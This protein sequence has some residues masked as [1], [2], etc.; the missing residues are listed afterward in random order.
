MGS[1]IKYKDLQLI[2]KFQILFWS[3]FGQEYCKWLPF[4]RET[5]AI[6]SESLV[7]AKVRFVRH[8]TAV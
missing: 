5:Q 4:K 3:G 6:E 1:Y 2:C 7:K 8:F